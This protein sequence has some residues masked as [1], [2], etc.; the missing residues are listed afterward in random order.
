MESSMGLFP[1]TPGTS[2]GSSAVSSTESVRLCV[3][4]ARPH[5]E[6]RSDFETIEKPAEEALIVGG[7]NG[8]PPGVRSLPGDCN[9]RLAQ[10]MQ[11]GGG[12]VYI[13]GIMRKGRGE[14]SLKSTP[15]GRG[16]DVDSASRWHQSRFSPGAVGTMPS[17]ITEPRESFDN[18]LRLPKGA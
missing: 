7:G 3:R 18:V 17:V 9:G 2:I 8:G 10:N 12:L 5:A 14:M 1:G 16:N 4:N 15:S 6:A 13:Q 11:Q